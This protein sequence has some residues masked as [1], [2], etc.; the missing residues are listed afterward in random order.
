[1][2]EIIKK[3]P[4]KYKPRPIQTETLNE[5]AD[6]WSKYDVFVINL[7]VASGKS[8]I[9][10]A[11]QNWQGTG[12]IITPNNLLVAQYRSDFENLAGIVGKAR[13]SCKEEGFDNCHRRGLKHKHPRTKKPRHCK[14]CPWVKDNRRF[15]SPYLKKYVTNNHLYAQMQRTMPVLIADEAHNLIDFLQDWHATRIS[16]SKYRYPRRA[17]IN[18]EELLV[19]LKSLRG[20][21]RIVTNPNRGEKG[22]ALLYNELTSGYS[23]FLLKEELE[24]KRDVQGNE[25][26]EIYLKLCPVDVRD[27]PPVLWPPSV[28]KIVLMS[29]TI[30][31]KDIEELGLQDRRIKYINADSCIPADRRPVTFIETSTVSGTKLKQSLPLVR[32]RV[33]SLAESNR[34]CKGVIHATYN[35]AELLKRCLDNPR[36]LYHTRKNKTQIYEAFRKTEEPVILIASGLYEGIDLPEDAGRWQVITKVPFPSLGEPAIRYR[37]TKDPD[38]YSWQASKVMLQATGRICRGPEDFGE[39]FVIDNS[40]RRLYT[41]HPEQYPDWFKESVRGI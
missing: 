31:E 21:D 28:K 39:T 41:D 22:L 30:N 4:N 13:Y 25:W 5:L 24:Y 37:M 20:I 29:A 12:A 26:T 33:L 9:A 2:Q 18:R 38:W 35:Q 1:M 3:F 7:P 40:F 10:K 23:R 16:W 17:G 34:D 36:F 14:D 11:I 27:M 8:Y 19:W 32:D 15:H 6:S